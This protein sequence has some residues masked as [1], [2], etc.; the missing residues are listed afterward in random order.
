MNPGLRR[1]ILDYRHVVWDWN[2]TLL[3]DAWL[4]VEIV[5]GLLHRRGK[6]PITLRQYGG[7]FDFP[8]ADYYRKIGLDCE[9]EPYE[10]IATEFIV[11]YERRRGECGLQPRAE[12]VLQAFADAGLT[13]SIL[14][15]YKQSR[16]EEVTTALGVRRF[17]S[18]LAGLDDH[19]A[20][21]KAEIGK[22]LLRTL[23]L[24]PSDVVFVGDTRHDYEVASVMGVDCLLI[25]SGHN[26][27][28]RLVS[29]GAPVLGS[30][31]ELGDLLDR[32]Q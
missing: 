4:C 12:R 20:A 9:G 5:N 15:A 30:V 28:E 32:T 6:A 7:F 22:H 8:V 24:S 1:D 11:E 14:S 23:S 26:S 27:R 21:G 2:G 3:D 10:K 16:L 25:P 19:Y 13:Q 18:N 17:F 29:C 31:A